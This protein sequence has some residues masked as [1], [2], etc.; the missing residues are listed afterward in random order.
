MAKT[1]GTADSLH[2]DYA[3]MSVPESERKS[4]YDVMAV[5]VGWAVSI[6]AFLVGGVISN[7]TTAPTGLAAIFF[8]NLALVVIAGLVGTIGF[9]TGLTTYSI[10][11]IIFGKKGSVIVSLFLGLLAMGFIGV[12]MSGFGAAIHKVV[13]AIPVV[14]ANIV[15]ALCITWSAVYGMKGLAILS[16]IAA[17]ALWI[18]LLVGLVVAF[19]E[20][21]SFTAVFMKAPVKPTGFGAA[22]GS[23]IATWVTGAILCSDIARYAKKPSH[24][25]GGAFAGYVLGA[26]VFEAGAMLMS[27][28]AGSPDV[29]VVMSNL[30][31]LL[32]GVLLLLLALWTT[33]DNNVYSSALAFTNAGEMLHIN[34]SKPVWTVI[35]VLIAVAVSLFNLASQFSIWLVLIGILAPP[36]GGIIIGHFWILNFRNKEFATPEGFSMVAFVSWIGAG[37]IAKFMIAPVPASVIGLVSALVIYT[38]LCLFFRRSSVQPKQQLKA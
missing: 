32:P 28:G 7:G 8:G 38:V 22:M 3:L 34:I 1:A 5:W 18:F 36:I 12:L 33:T 2:N 4:F 25:W 9:R 16:R 11:R 20:P 21:G 14:V 10:G 19:K 24:I 31:L 27:K 35:A 29:V 6:S 15:F 37:L 17:P 26:G 23:A 30:G 13:P